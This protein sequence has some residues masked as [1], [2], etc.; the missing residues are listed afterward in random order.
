LAGERGTVLV[1]VAVALLALLALS[2]FVLDHGVM[3]SGRG[4]AQNAADAGALGGAKSLVNQ[5]GGAHAEMAARM[6]ALRHFVA[7]DPLTTNNIT[8][9][10]PVPQPCP[11]PYAGATACV[12]VDI[13]K[14]NVPTFFARL[15]NVNT[16]GV[17][18]TAT[19]MAGA[20]NATSCLRPW[21]VPDL[22]QNNNADP[23]FNDGVD[24]Y[25]APVPG[26]G[27]G[28]TAAMI[29][30][31]ITLT[32]GRPGDAMAPGIFFEADLDGGG[33]GT[34]QYISNI[35][36]C[37]GILKHIN[38]TGTCP[39][40]D[41][42]PGCVNVLNGRR[43][44]ANVQG[45]ETLI[46]ADPSAYVDVAN[47]R[48]VSGCAPNCPGYEGQETSPRLVPVAMFNPQTF[49]DAGSHGNI[50]LPIVNIMA[51]FV[52]S[53]VTSGHN[54]GNIQGVIVSDA[55]LFMQGGGSAGPASFLRATVLVR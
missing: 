12:K 40:G 25:R 34:P 46:D 42:D 50:S 13:S 9:V 5:Q 15:A 8:V 44:N 35:E 38:S 17:R 27:T 33:G 23:N 52:Q 26:P 1:Q 47:R 39:L 24:V 7:G 2:A 18:A 48:V 14:Q 55:A 19:A 29:G 28:Y 21:F 31:P 37:S 43:P 36:H 45:A 6:M 11:A 41:A 49:V 4:A 32:A 10:L 20:G 53:V 22:W 51:V 54:R 30:T 16:Q 3:T